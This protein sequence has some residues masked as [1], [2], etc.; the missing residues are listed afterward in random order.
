MEGEEQFRNNP[1]KRKAKYELPIDNPWQRKG[2]PILPGSGTR[3]HTSTE[4]FDA[5]E[6][7]NMGLDVDT[8]R[9]GLKISPSV[10]GVVSFRGG[11]ALFRGSGTIIDC[12]NNNGT[13]Q[14]TIL[15]SGSVLR[16]S[17]LHVPSDIEVDVYMFDGRLY[18][19]CVFACDLYF[20]IASIKVNSDAPLPKA[21]LINLDDSNTIDPSQIKTFRSRFHSTSFKISPDDT[22]VAMGRHYEQPYNLMGVRGKFSLASCNIGWGE[23]LRTNCKIL[24]SGT[25][26]PL[27]NRYGQVI[28]VAF[29][30][31]FY[32]PF[33]PINIALKCMEHFEKDGKVHRPWL[34]IEVTNL[35][36][37]DLN[38]LE[39][40][41]RIFPNTFTGVLVEEVIPNSPAEVAGILPGD[42]IAQC[43]G[44][45]VQNCLELFRILMDKV[46]DSV[47][48]LILRE[49]SG[50]SLNRSVKVA[51]VSQDGFL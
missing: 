41:I 34:G 38:K 14:S 5:F 39:R 4:E 30:E 13:Y 33:L 31:E 46:G 22:V 12:V 28:G 43:D 37:A 15:T 11:S 19:G 20:N 16:S 45:I 25:G 36:T 51:E 49:G 50:E 17:D 48:V 29:Y 9:A 6:L 32:T 47:K 10:V 40:I 26:G 18:K 2:K 3:L 21:D 24:K 23:F 44:N 35:Y 27:I 42:V 7:V 1:V 8:K